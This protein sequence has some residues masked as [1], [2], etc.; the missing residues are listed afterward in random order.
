MVTTAT[1]PLLAYTGLG[2]LSR[3]DSRMPSRSTEAFLGRESDGG[4]PDGRAVGRKGGTLET[5][6]VGVGVGAAVASDPEGA[7]AE[8]DGAVGAGRPHAALATITTVRASVRSGLL[9]VM[10]TSVGSQTGDGHRG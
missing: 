5:A 1:A 8:V 6:G 3:R 4:A 10:P 9:A 7:G 2:P